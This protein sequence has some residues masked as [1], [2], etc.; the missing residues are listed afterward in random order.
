MCC[1][2][3]FFDDYIEGCFVRYLMEAPG[4]KAV[5]RACQI[6][7][8]GRTERGYK[9]NTG[10]GDMDTKVVLKLNSQGVTVDRKRLDK[11]SNHTLTE[12]EVSKH[13]TG[14]VE[15]QIQ[16]L[17]KRE[18]RVKHQRLRDYTRSYVYSNEEVQS[19]I[20][21]R[22]GL[23]QVFATDYTTALAELQKTL[24]KA[25]QERNFD[26]M[27]VTQKEIEKLT[28][29]NERQKKVYEKTYKVHADVNRKMRE[30]NTKR[31]MEAGMR[32]RR[33]DQEAAAKG[34]LSHSVTDPF[35][36]R[37]T[38]P[39]NLWMTTSHRPPPKPEDG[40][41]QSTATAASTTADSTT[42]AAA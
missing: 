2:S 17:T 20:A 37:E 38:R 40:T 9:I 21:Q 10:K 1:R 13:I 16:P 39:K 27:E 18:I 33:E 31:D 15:R 34:I 3:P 28:Y 35:V 36:R 32:K 29:E 22:T 11:I 8:V 12:D 23:N 7:E 42:D 4:G 5:Y 24:V 30:M 41:T 25:T 26:L 6:V 14:L 19:M